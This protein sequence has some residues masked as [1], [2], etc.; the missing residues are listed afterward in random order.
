MVLDIWKLTRPLRVALRSGKV[1]PRR[2]KQIWATEISWDTAPP[3]PDG[4]P[5][6]RQARYLEGA[7]Y[8]L[9]RQGVDVVA[10]F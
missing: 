3:D 2:H 1:R 7:F 8:T 4:I 6:R 9:W 5:I 10:W